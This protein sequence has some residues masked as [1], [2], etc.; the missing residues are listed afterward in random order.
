[1]SPKHFFF[2]FFFLSKQAGISGNFKD[3][4]VLLCEI[5]LTVSVCPMSLSGSNDMKRCVWNMKSNAVSISC[6][7]NVSDARSPA[8]GS[9][10][11]AGLLLASPEEGGVAGPLC[12]RA[13]RHCPLAAAFCTAVV[14]ALWLTGEPTSFL[15]GLFLTHPSSINPHLK[16]SVCVLWVGERCSFPCYSR[17]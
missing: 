3:L 13:S 15:V 12:P 16:F 6:R 10:G 11:T 2:F 4:P 5:G 7:N 8:L 9:F 1:M 14:S 17:N